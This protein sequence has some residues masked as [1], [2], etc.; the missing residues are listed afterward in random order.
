[1]SVF[2]RTK[3]TAT[4]GCPPEL[5]SA[6]ALKEMC[7]HGMQGVTLLRDQRNKILLVDIPG[8][9]KYVVKSYRKPNLPQRIAYTFFT[10]GKARRA[11]NAGMELL[12]RQLGTPHPEAYIEEY[13]GGL[14]SHSY[15]ISRYTP[16]RTLLDIWVWQPDYSREILRTLIEHLVKMHTSGVLHGDPNLGNFLYLPDTGQIELVDTNRTRFFTSLSRRQCL[17]NM[18]RLTHRHDLMMEIVGGYARARGWDAGACTA[19]VMNK[20]NRYEHKRH[21][22]ETLK[23]A[24][25]PWRYK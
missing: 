14:L 9:G 8:Q 20:L 2:S 5:T 13:A 22:R 23:R 4:P 18:V 10:P 17:D 12:R 15:F 25:L 11:Y 16:A 6:S 7:L 19:Y 1:M 24:L 21:R 3:V